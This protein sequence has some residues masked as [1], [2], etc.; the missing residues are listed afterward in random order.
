MCVH[1][2]VYIHINGLINVNPQGKT[3]LIILKGEQSRA[4]VENICCS[5]ED[6]SVA[7]SIHGWLTI[8]Y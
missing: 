7:A 4:A 2:H 6:Q 8:I 1:M 3:V 5:A